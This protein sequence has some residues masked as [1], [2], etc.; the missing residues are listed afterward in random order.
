M[1]RKSCDVRR[2]VEMLVFSLR[3]EDL[4]DRIIAFKYLGRD[5]GLKRETCLQKREY[6]HLFHLSPKN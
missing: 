3:K 6:V 1:V 2:D 5:C 4:M